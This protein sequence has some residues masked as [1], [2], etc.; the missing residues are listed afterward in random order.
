MVFRLELSYT[1]ILNTLD[2]K[3]ID[4]STTGYTLPPGVYEFSDINSTIKSLL[5]D[6]FIVNITI[7]DIR[8]KSNKTNNK[9]LRFTEKAFFYSLLGLTQS[10]SGPLN[11]IEGFVQLI[12]GTYK[13]DK[14]INNTG[15]DKVHLKCDCIDGSIV[16]GVREPILYS[17][18]LS[19]A[20]GHKIFKEPRIKLFKKINK[21][22]LSHITFYL[23]NND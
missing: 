14:L 15:V 11:D 21:S 5:P 19:S 8:L 1:E 2:M 6:G 23:K 3:Y 16:N 17:F 4:A 18:G 22:V 13:S 12:P 7:D 10:H 20:P 9:T